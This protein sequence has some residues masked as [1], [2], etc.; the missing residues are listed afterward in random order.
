LEGISG[1]I[2]IAAL[3]AWWCRSSGVKWLSSIS[4]YSARPSSPVNFPALKG[5]SILCCAHELQLD[6]AFEGASSVGNIIYPLWDRHFAMKSL[7]KA[8]YDLYNWPP[9]NDL[10]ACQCGLRIS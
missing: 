4:H 7:E 8:H 9:N 1:D 10:M 2:L 5:R 3:A 6:A